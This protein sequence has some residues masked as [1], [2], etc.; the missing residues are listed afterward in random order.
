MFK[1]LFR[2][3]FKEDVT[4][5]TFLNSSEAWRELS[6]NDPDLLV[7]RD[8]MLGLTGEEICRRLFEQKATFPI[9]VT[10]GWPPTEKWVREYASRGLNIKFLLSPFT[11]EQFNKELLTYF[12][13]SDNPSVKFQKSEP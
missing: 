13:P 11:V 5:I 1:I 10:G 9:I 8:R 7:T 4:L 12:G 3:W 6:Q 2:N